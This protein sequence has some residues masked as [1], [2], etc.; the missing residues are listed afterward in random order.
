MSLKVSPC[1]HGA[2][3]W[4]PQLCRYASAG[5]LSDI[6]INL[7]RASP[8]IKLFGTWQLLKGQR[9]IKRRFTRMKMSCLTYNLWYFYTQ[10]K[11]Y[12]INIH[13]THTHTHTLL[14]NAALACMDSRTHPHIMSVLAECM[15]CHFESTSVLCTGSCKIF[16]TICHVQVS[17]GNQ[18]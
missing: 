16:S 7:S 15:H 18:R 2:L 13:N 8:S 1:P 9:G 10:D 14:H 5:Q 17:Q 12:C 6:A 4:H 3:G 11:T